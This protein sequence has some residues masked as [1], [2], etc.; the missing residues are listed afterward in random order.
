MSKKLFV[1]NLVFSVQ[2]SDLK[3]LFAPYGEIA[4]A[5]IIKDKFS[6][7]SKGFGFVTLSDDEAALKAIAELHDKEFQG[8]KLTVNEARP[9][10]ERSPSDRPR[11]SFGGE[12]R[13][14]DGERGS[15]NRNRF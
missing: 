11:R 5:V 6:G 13:S 15:F 10:E 8:R 4:E 1:G 3:T 2:D 12:Q 7:R 9:M 14:F